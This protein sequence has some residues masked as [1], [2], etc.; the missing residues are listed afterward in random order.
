MTR[1]AKA[2]TAAEA[3]TAAAAAPNPGGQQQAAQ[4]V[5]APKPGGLPVWKPPPFSVPEGE[6]TW[7]KGD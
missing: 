3:A 5:G 1:G 7:M 6:Y 4:S 2:A